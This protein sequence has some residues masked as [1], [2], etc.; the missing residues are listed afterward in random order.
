[1][2][3]IEPGETCNLYV[4]H[5]GATKLVAVISGE[6]APDWSVNCRSTARVSPDGVW[7]A[8]MSQ[9]S[10]TGYNNRDAVSGKPG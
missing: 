4:H 3:R 10:L 1:M 9:R 8:F 5:D 6:D 2:N 7:L